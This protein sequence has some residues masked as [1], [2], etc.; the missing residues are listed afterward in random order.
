MPSGLLVRDCAPGGRGRADVRLRFGT[1]VEIGPGLRREGEPV[2]DA[3]GATLL[4]GLHDHHLHLHALAAALGSVDCGPPAVRSMDALAAALR[5]AV[6]GAVRGTGYHESVAG[7]LD[8][9][10][11]DGLVGTVPVRVQHRSGAAWFLNSEALLATGLADSPD[12]AVERDDLGRPTGRLLRGD[13]LLRSADDALPDLAG[14]GRLLASY[15]VT[16]VAD[17]TPSLAPRALDALREARALGTLPQHLLL[18]GAPLEDRGDDVGPWKVLLDEAAGLDLDDLVEVLRACRAVDRPV[19]FHAVTTAEAVVAVAAL[20]AVGRLAGD[21]VEHGSLLPP[22]LDSELRLLGVTVVTQPHFVAERGD[23]YLADVDPR[24]TG[25]LYRCASLLAGGVAVATGTDAP[26]GG[27]DPWRTVAAAVARRTPSGAVL[28][29]VEQLPADRALALL[30]GPLRAPGGA[31]RRVEPGAAADLVLVEGPLE[32][33]L[34]EPTSQRVVATVIAGR[35][36]W[37]R[38]PG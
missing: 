28:G 11:L 21:R 3:G 9:W 25:H 1:V 4:P 29:A 20:R 34:R 10:V 27:L 37:A 8:R 12:P 30:Q 15:G 7:P 6:P 2:L 26:Y 18:L 23:D 31:V 5:G 14:V 38:D 16:G 24:D 35:V 32:G 17:A 36:A 13:H 19:A 22:S 33:V